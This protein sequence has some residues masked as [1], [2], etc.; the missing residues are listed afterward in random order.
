MNMTLVESHW[1]KSASFIENS[2]WRYILTNEIP[3]IEATITND[4]LIL[5]FDEVV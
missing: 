2:R 4:G 1:K 3:T 5:K